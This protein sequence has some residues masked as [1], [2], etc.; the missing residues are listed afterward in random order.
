MDTPARVD[1]GLRAQSG[2]WPVPTSLTGTTLIDTV[3]RHGLDAVAQVDLDSRAHRHQGN[4]DLAVM[5]AELL[6]VAEKR[7]AGGPGMTGEIT[8]EQFERADGQL[9]RR[10]RPVPIDE[11]PPARTV[12]AVGQA[13]PVRTAG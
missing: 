1:A 8:L 13:R 9:L 12:L 2:G 10:S 4:H 5:A 3:S 7:R 6:A 11:R